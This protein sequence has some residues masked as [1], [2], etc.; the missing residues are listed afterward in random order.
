VAH[1]R[2]ARSDRHPRGERGRQL[3]APR[4]PRSNE[5]SRVACVSGR[6]SHGDVSYHQEH[7][8][9]DEGTEG[10]YH[11]D[12]LLESPKPRS[13]RSLTFTPS[14]VWVHRK[15]WPARLGS[16]RPTTLRGLPALSWT[17]RVGPWWY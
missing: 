14:G 10:G 1:R 13:T 4:S 15:T 8:A 17:W 9:R 3:H 11:R 6:Q 12:D 16:S 5:R 7:S 2:G